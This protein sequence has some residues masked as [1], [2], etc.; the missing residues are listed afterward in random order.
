MDVSVIGS[1]MLDTIIH[2]NRLKRF[3]KGKKPYL[4]FPYSSKTEIEELRFDVGGS[5]HNI[6]VG[7]SKLGNNVIFI[8]RIGN[9]PNG[10]MILN[11]FKEEGVDTTY[12]KKDESKMTG[13]SQIF[14]TPNGEKSL[15]TYRGANNNLIPDDIPEAIK[16]TNWFVF[17]TVTSDQTVEAVKKSVELVKNNG[18]RVLANPSIT[19]VK[20]RKEELTNLIRKS[21]VAI[22]N[23]EEVCELTNTRNEKKGLKDLLKL[24]VKSAVVTLGKKGIIASNGENYYKQKPYN[25]KINDTTGAGDGFTAGFLHWF[26]KTDSFKD[27]LMFG[28]ATAALNIE[29]VGA[30]KNLPSENDIINLMER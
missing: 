1:A 29:S 2:T 30:T 18:G 27:S 11:N 22:M 3:K 13:F 21:D 8:G 6:A 28:N 7:I 17:T 19:M 26:M 14:I 20:H 16:N 10:E 5:G 4:G 25:V 24:G 15:L 23:K 12:I 9:D